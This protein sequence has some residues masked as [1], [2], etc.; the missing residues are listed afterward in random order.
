[1]EEFKKAWWKDIFSKNM[2][3]EMPTTS[4]TM[5]IAKIMA[6]WENIRF[7]NRF[8]EIGLSFGFSYINW[9]FGNSSKN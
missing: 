4:E 3:P 2:N 5:I 6:R 9:P 1:M 8:L 7:K